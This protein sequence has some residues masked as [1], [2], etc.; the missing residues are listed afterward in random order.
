MVEF[1]VIPK[2]T[3]DRS[4]QSLPI[5]QENIQKP[6]VRVWMAT[7]KQFNIRP[8]ASTMYFGSRC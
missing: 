2:V 1:N 3:H 6:Y 5:Q 8:D 4:Y 7:Q